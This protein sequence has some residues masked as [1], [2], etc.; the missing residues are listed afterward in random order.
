MADDV[1]RE[2]AAIWAQDRSGVLG[3]D[4]EL[5]WHVPAEARHFRAATSGATV[6]MGRH[7][8]ESLPQ[9]FRP[10]PRRRNVVV[11]RDAAYDAPGAEVVTTPEA[12]AAVPSATDTT[13]VMGGAGIYA[14]LLPRCER[15]VVS[16][17]DLDV[18]AERAE[19]PR[20]LLRAPH[21]DPAHWRLADDGPWMPGDADRDDLA[22]ASAPRWRV[23]TYVRR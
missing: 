22:P 1:A 18:L 14:A 8:W 2:L 15:L 21:I 11:T 6:V 23:R 12:A 17:I 7:T 10:L 3:L 16:E 5:P 13:W 9:R 4:G 19:G 20:R